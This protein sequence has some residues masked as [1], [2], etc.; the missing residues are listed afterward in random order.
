MVLRYHSVAYDYPPQAERY[1]VLLEKASTMLSKTLH[2]HRINLRQLI[3]LTV[4]VCDLMFLHQD[5]E[6]ESLLK[7]LGH[8]LG[9]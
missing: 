3:Q 2:Q 7:E 8:G 6:S 4:T 1:K 5:Y 9:V